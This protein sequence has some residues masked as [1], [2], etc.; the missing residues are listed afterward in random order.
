MPTEENITRK[1][2]AILSADV[3]RYSLLMA[4]AEVATFQTFKNHRNI[5][6]ICIEQHGGKVVDA[7]GD[8]F[9]VSQSI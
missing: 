4:D 2:R 8:I 5:M 6:S 7:A 1:L 9:I 3:K